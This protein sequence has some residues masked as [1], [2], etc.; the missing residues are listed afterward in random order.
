MVAHGGNS[1]AGSFIQ[2]LT[3]VD[4]ATGWTECLPEVGSILG[5]DSHR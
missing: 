3:M 2:T 1:V 4:I 5:A